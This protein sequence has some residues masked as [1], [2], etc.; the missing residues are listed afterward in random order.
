[1][2]Q[3]EGGRKE[4]RGGKGEETNKIIRGMKGKEGRKEGREGREKGSVNGWRGGK[5][6]GTR[7]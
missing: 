3:I 2:L 7:N 5:K 1:M 6:K 4:R